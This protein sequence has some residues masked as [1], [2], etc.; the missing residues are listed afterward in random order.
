MNNPYDALLER[1]RES[2][3]KGLARPYTRSRNME[4]INDT[5]QVLA[6]A[7]RLDEE[8]IRT[9]GIATDSRE[10][11][12]CAARNGRLEEA[13]MLIAAARTIYGS[14]NLSTQASECAEAFQT[15][16]ESYVQYKSSDYAAAVLSMSHSLRLCE[17]LANTYGYPLEMRRI[18]L[19]RNI[20]RIRASAGYTEEAL[21][22]CAKLLQYIGG[23]EDAWPLPY[24]GQ[25]RRHLLYDDAA[26]FI[27]DQ[28]LAEA[29]RLF[30][31]DTT[32]AIENLAAVAQARDVF[33]FG[34]SAFL[35]AAHCLSACV[36]YVEGNT[37][38]S[39][40]EASAFFEVGPQSLEF[41]WREMEKR[42]L[43]ENCAFGLQKHR[44]SLETAVA[45]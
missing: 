34:S 45:K 44:E 20:A 18:H 32:A 30:E 38:A 25:A 31:P 23:N 11:G 35:R 4:Q 43:L 19:A 28:V 6:M 36:S 40:D 8:E 3:R 5:L 7:E 2:H 29:L 39:L 17:V 21:R 15:A 33:V 1:M 16:A 13:I 41:A 26:L 10:R 14:A 24:S 37:H 27:L 42:F 12:L 9:L 22:I